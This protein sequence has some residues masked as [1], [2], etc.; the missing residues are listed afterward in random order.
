MS[1]S[2]ATNKQA[3]HNYEVLEKY[4]AGL[5]LSG[6]EVKSIK[7]GNVNIKP[8]YASL[9]NG[10]VFLKNVHVSPYKPA[11]KDNLDP[12]RTR[13]LLLNHKEI[14]VLDRALN[15]QG[16][17]IVPLDLHLKKGRIKVTLGLCRGKKAHDKRH[18]LKKKDQNI[19]IK[20]ALKN[21]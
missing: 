1:A 11:E 14:D 21:Y 2:I 3:F 12:D 16:L 10:E 6:P 8:G 20:R 5:V 4:E 15:T 9:E 19:E 13:K 17:T 7:A 18:D